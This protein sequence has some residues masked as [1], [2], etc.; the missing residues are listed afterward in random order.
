MDQKLFN[1]PRF[2]DSE[3]FLELS[4]D[5]LQERNTKLK[6]ERRENKTSEYFADKLIAQL[7]KESSIKAVTVCF[8]DMEGKLHM[9]DYNK[10]FLLESPRLKIIVKRKIKILKKEKERGLRFLSR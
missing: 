4:Y 7:H 3:N 6:M 8:S 2:R 5:E 10:A 1:T 9:L